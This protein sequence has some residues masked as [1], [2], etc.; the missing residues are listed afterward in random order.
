[1]T[2]TLADGNSPHDLYFFEQTQEMLA[3]EVTPPGV[4]LRAAEVLRRQLFAFC[5]DDWV[6]SGVPVTA[7]PEGPPG[8]WTPWRERTRAA[9]RSPFSTMC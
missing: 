6:G 9:F 4:F 2:T 1:M 5:L 8:P 7:L 3:G